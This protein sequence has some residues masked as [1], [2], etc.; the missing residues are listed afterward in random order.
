MT[1]IASD[2]NMHLMLKYYAHICLKSDLDMAILL[3]PR[4]LQPHSQKWLVYGFN[5][6]ENY[7]KISLFFYKTKQNLHPGKKTILVNTLFAVKF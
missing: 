2:E 3:I 5:Q 7:D 4:F 6:I 1:R